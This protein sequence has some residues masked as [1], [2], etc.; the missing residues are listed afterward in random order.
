MVV[1]HFL[2]SER[3]SWGENQFADC[4]VAY[5]SFLEGCDMKFD[6]GFSA[7]YLFSLIRF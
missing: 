6:V 4:L 2:N 1:R 7:G 5:C 3:I